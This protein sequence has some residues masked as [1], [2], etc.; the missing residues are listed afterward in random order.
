MFA[1]C[2]II[3]HAS[4]KGQKWTGRSVRTTDRRTGNRR[5]SVRVSA[6]RPG[7]PPAYR[8]NGAVPSQRVSR[9]DARVER[10]PRGRWSRTAHRRTGH[11]TSAPASGHVG[12]LPG[13]AVPQRSRGSRS[14]SPASGR[15]RPDTR[16]L[17]RSTSPASPS[18]ALAALLSHSS[19]RRGPR[20]RPR[21]L[22]PAPTRAANS[23][24]SLKPRAKPSAA[25]GTDS[26][27][28]STR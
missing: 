27:P 14:S 7:P 15:L 2:I 12:R 17:S 1:P 6:V 3:P 11:P 28:N 4:T 20:E 9:F 10:R 8:R 24:P 5:R 21:R 22:R 26:P 16:G 19:R 25:S 13:A 23:W 18:S